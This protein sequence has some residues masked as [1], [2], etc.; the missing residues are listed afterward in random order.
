MARVRQH[1]AYADTRGELADYKDA[2]RGASED[3]FWDEDELVDYRPSKK[4][5][6]KRQKGCPEN[7]GGRHIYVWQKDL[8][9]WW[10]RYYPDS[11]YEKKLCCGCE[12]RAPG[13]SFRR[14]RD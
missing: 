1:F 14:K 10:N 13:I 6:R 11:P 12:K 2:R 3:A 7:N 9:P 8:D 4:K 5:K